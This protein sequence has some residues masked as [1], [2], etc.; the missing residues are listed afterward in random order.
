MYKLYKVGSLARFYFGEIC[1]FKFRQNKT[2][3][4]PAIQYPRPLLGKGKGG[5]FVLLFFENVYSCT[6]MMQN[7]Q[8]FLDL[9]L[10][11]RG[12]FVFV[13]QKGTKALVKQ[14]RI[15]KFFWGYYPW[16]HYRR[17][18]IGKVASSWNYVWLHPCLGIQSVAK[19]WYGRLRWF[20]H[21]ESKS[22]D[23]WSL[24]CLCHAAAMM[25]FVT[26][27]TG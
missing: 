21:L 13:L 1:K 8:I 5:Q 11:G 9:L 18:G 24:A 19:V 17:E 3:N 14:C 6:A 4:I 2:R 15:H 25:K 10:E 22:R 26:T 16:P 20:G 27:S 23:D 12:K 7:S